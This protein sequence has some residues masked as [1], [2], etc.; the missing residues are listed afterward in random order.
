MYNYHCYKNDAF[1]FYAGSAPSIRQVGHL[2]PVNFNVWT[3]SS[4][5]IVVLSLV[6]LIY[7][8]SRHSGA[9]DVEKSYNFFS[10]IIHV[11]NL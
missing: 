11:K 5:I 10:G 7:E 9:T 1:I 4:I 8:P 3:A 2:G 6:V